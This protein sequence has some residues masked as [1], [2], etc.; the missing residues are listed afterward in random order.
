MYNL[1]NFY[2]SD[3]EMDSS[4]KELEAMIL[5][6]AKLDREINCFMDI[7]KEV[8]SEVIVVTDNNLIN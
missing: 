4:I 3:E 2:I 1:C 5:D 8:T 6:C 7:A